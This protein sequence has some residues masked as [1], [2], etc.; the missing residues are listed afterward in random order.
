MIVSLQRLLDVVAEARDSVTALTLDHKFSCE[1]EPFKQDWIVQNF[2]PPLLFSDIGELENEKA[3][4]IVH[5]AECEV[6]D[7]EIFAAGFSCKDVSGMNKN[8]AEYQ[9]CAEEGKGTTGGTLQGAMGYVQR[10]RPPM[11]F[12]ENVVKL[13][14]SSSRAAPQTSEFFDPKHPKVKN[15]LKVVVKLLE[16][17]GYKV[18]VAVVDSSE[19]FLPQR[20]RRI[21]IHG[22]WVPRFPWSRLL[23]N[24]MAHCEQIMNRA[25]QLQKQTM[26]PLTEFFMKPGTPE[27]AKWVE[28][29]AFDSDDDPDDSDD[30]RP[31]ATLYA[32]A[33]AAAKA[34]ARAKAKAKYLAPFRRVRKKSPGPRQ[35][36]VKR[37]DKY[38]KL[39]R[40]QFAKYG[41]TWPVVSLDDDG[42][43]KEGR[44]KEVLHFQKQLAARREYDVGTLLVLDSSQ[45]VH[46]CPI[47]VNMTP[48]LCPRS[49]M[50]VLQLT[51]QGWKTFHRLPA[52][53]H[54]FLQGL[55]WSDCPA[56]DK[57]SASQIRDLAGNAFCGLAFAMSITC[58]LVAY[59]V[60]PYHY[61]RTCIAQAQQGDGAVSVSGDS[62]D[63][64]DLGAKM[65]VQDGTET[66]VEEALSD[67]EDLNFVFHDKPAA[68]ADAEAE[69]E[70]EAEAQDT[71]SDDEEVSPLGFPVMGN[72]YVG[73]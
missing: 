9:N 13:G 45:S 29:A 17:L 53:S 65:L 35:E 69:A 21:F 32:K 52:P 26:L 57:F 33:K 43:G 34:K 16:E 51:D 22:V 27:H 12:L 11:V 70:A 49:R 40:V 66:E 67:H 42:F 64:A 28:H 55:H 14:F 37:G 68:T 1:I 62:D 31:L 8:A 60:P 50:H 41:L 7:C 73:F 47:G 59:E 3:H 15:N 56:I 24:G 2:N 20:R 25:M 4:C 10:H 39:H 18:A 61:W 36:E 71:S 23:I 72:V 48:C 44:E 38:K 6:P 30:E 46:R 54:L 58:V 19:F 5:D 63:S